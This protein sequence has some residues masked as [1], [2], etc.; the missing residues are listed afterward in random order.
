MSDARAL[1]RRAALLAAHEDL[2]AAVREFGAA[3]FDADHTWNEL[4]QTATRV[5]EAA[6]AWARAR[7]AL[8]PCRWRLTELTLAEGA[9]LPEEDF[10]DALRALHEAAETVAELIIDSTLPSA[11]SAA[12]QILGRAAAHFHHLTRVVVAFEVALE[13]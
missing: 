5:D 13:D 12:R 6:L 8:G 11:T 4:E 1:D 9:A 7:R 10:L 2:L 3:V